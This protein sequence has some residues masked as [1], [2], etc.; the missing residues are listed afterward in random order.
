MLA[1]TLLST[2]AY[3]QRN[4]VPQEAVPAEVQD[5][6]G[7]AAITAASKA[8]CRSCKL[9]GRPAHA[10]PALTSLHLGRVCPWQVEADLV[11]AFAAALGVAAEALPPVVFSRCQ[12]WGA[13]GLGAGAAC[14]PCPWHAAWHA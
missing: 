5:K 1:G 7:V 3:G 4:K 13:G 9:V 8:Y 11:A 6:V 10:A 2:N 12:L 14:L